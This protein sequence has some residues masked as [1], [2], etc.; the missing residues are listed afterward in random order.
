MALQQLQVTCINKRDRNSTHEGITHVGGAGW[1]WT[2]AQAIRAIKYDKTHQLYT[3]VG[4]KI[5]WVGVNGSPP[6]EYLQTHADG[7]WN[8]NLLALPECR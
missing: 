1:K 5:A 6:N 4:G 3:N 8:N 7:R 2:R